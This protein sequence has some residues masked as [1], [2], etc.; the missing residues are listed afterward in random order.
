M[1]LEIFKKIESLGLFC[2][3]HLT[4]FV[5]FNF[6]G[7]YFR[8]T[9][10]FLHLMRRFQIFLEFY[11]WWFTWHCFIV[12]TIGISNNNY[13][14]WTIHFFR[15][16][17]CSPLFQISFRLFP[18]ILFLF[19]NRSKSMNQKGEKKDWNHYLDYWICNCISNRLNQWFIYF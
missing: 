6:C 16:S 11:L 17:F 15:S 7:W 13:Q 4:T 2:A 5:F 12:F 14:L 19:S 3:V 9:I 1:P 8:F 10:N 18:E